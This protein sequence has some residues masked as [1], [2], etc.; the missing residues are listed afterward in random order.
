ML[1]L[2]VDYEPGSVFLEVEGFLDRTTSTTLVDWVHAVLFQKD[3]LR[4]TFD[5]QQLHVE[6]GLSLIALERLRKIL[7][8]RFPAFEYRGLGAPAIE[9][10]TEEA[11]CT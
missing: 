2:S 3:G 11:A 8:H 10:G 4:V 7:S 5:C 9:A 1:G 6:D